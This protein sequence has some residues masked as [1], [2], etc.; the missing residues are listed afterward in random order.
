MSIKDLQAKYKIGL[1]FFLDSIKV[2]LFKIY[3]NWFRLQKNI[4]SNIKLWRTTNIFKKN[5]NREQRLFFVASLRVIVIPWRPCLLTTHLSTKLHI[6]Q[7]FFKNFTLKTA[8]S[9]V[10]FLG[11]FLSPTG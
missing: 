9:V 7:N 4:L 10:W 11:K 2:E 5:L 6:W 3:N 8:K 1:Q